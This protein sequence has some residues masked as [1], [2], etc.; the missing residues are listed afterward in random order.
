MMYIM[1]F[2]KVTRHRIVSKVN[3]RHR[4]YETR[5]GLAFPRRVNSHISA[6]AIG[7]LYV[8]LARTF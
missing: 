6:Q 2:F 5:C 3:H 1:T 8:V 4:E 7:N